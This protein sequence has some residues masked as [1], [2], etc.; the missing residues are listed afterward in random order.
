MLAELWDGG[1]W[2]GHKCLCL[3]DE[4]AQKLDGFKGM[5]LKILLASVLAGQVRQ[6]A[7][8]CRISMMVWGSMPPSSASLHNSCNFALS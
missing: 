1:V 2:Y 5:Y 4:L 7:A 6:S 3:A 8:I